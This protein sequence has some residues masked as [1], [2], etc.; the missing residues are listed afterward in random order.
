MDSYRKVLLG[1]FDASGIPRPPD[2]SEL[3]FAMDYDEAARRACI[4][5]FPWCIRVVCIWHMNRVIRRAWRAKLGPDFADFML[6]LSYCWT[7]MTEEQFM[8]SWVS[9]SELFPQDLIDYMMRTWYP[10]WESWARYAIGHQFTAATTATLRSKASHAKLERSGSSRQ[11]LVEFK[12]Q[13]WDPFLMSEER[14]WQE[15][16]DKTAHGCGVTA[17]ELR[18]TR[19][20]FGEIIDVWS[21]LVTHHWL[22]IF[23]NRLMDSLPYQVCL[24]VSI[25]LSGV[26]LTFWTRPLLFM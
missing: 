21:K 14:Q 23:V 9:L 8:S 19:P 3:V 13:R 22:T 26:V 16:L 11:S 24:A 7:Q 17:Q 10:V 6:Q 18:T 25:R 12:C 5:T 1:M 15:E 4:E 2:W 20:M